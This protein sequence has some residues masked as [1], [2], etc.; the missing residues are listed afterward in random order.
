MEEYHNGNR[1][2]HRWIA[3]ADADNRGRIYTEFEADR[4]E[5]WQSGGDEHNAE[6]VMM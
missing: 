4:V 1:N 5:F 3:C 2:A 6:Y